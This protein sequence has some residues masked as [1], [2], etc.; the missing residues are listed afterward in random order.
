MTSCHATQTRFSKFC[1]ADPVDHPQDEASK[2][3][4]L[5]AKIDL[6]GRKRQRSE[7]EG[8]EDDALACLER[9]YK[10]LLNQLTLSPSVNTKPPNYSSYQK[11]PTPILD[12]RYSDTAHAPALPVE[13]YHP[14]FAVFRG[15]SENTSIR[16]PDE[17]IR[18]TR[19]LMMST[20]QIQTGESMSTRALLSE[21]LAPGLTQTVNL[22]RSW[23][24]H[25]FTQGR[26]EKPF[27]YASPL[28]IAEK[29]DLGTGGDCS[30]Q[31]SF[32]F[33]STWLQ[34]Q[35]ISSVC[36]CPSFVIGIAGPW[37]VIMGAIF[38]SHII[39]QRLTGF[40]WLGL[41]RA[42]NENRVVQL[43]R[44][45][46]ALRLGVKRLSEY[47][48]QTIFSPTARKDRF[49]PLATSYR[50][51]EDRVVEFHYLRP[52][53]KSN[54]SCAAF[55]V[56]RKNSGQQMVVKFVERYGKDAHSLL[57]TH[58]FA[59]PLLYC[60]SVWMSGHEEMGCSSWKM[61]VM[62]YIPGA[63]LAE[64]YGNKEV[65]DSVRVAVRTATQLLHDKDLVHGDLRRPNIMVPADHGAGHRDV[66]IVDFDWSGRDGEAYY[67]LNL[68]KSIAWPTGVEECGAI[69]KCHDLAMIDLL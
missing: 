50:D 63:T 11:G 18:G 55:L 65:P 68:S 31:G 69:I 54:P 25:S 10:R 62:E 36:F 48:N 41:D 61:V 37:I 59:P 45:F 58:K 13:L 42:I 66:L 16:P 7:I 15:V 5:I 32:S 47:Y 67:P 26:T 52:L 46:Y 39:V 1:R 30:V 57:Q 35:Y 43:A 8:E 51:H 64:E 4:A 28:I 60:G 6:A 49:Y 29:P 40:L 2:N 27:G 24:D 21:L 9:G 33:Q 34:N 53:Q 14:A 20:S 44:V 22:D 19:N 56:Q 12:G 38:T 17:V 23:P 3:T